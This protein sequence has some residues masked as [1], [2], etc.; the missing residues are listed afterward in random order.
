MAQIKNRFTRLLNVGGVDIRPGATANVREWDAIKD[1]P[2]I[3]TWVNGGVLEVVSTDNGGNS[4]L[5]PVP[6]TTNDG[7]TDI[8]KMTVPQLQAFLTSKNIAYSDE[9]KPELLELA[10]EASK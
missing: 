10:R 5:P 2:V 7:E 4:L 3:K 1:G 6:S 9:K 8:E